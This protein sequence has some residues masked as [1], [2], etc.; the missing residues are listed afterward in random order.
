MKLFSL[1]IIFVLIGFCSDAQSNESQF[2]SIDSFIFKTGPL[3]SYNVA[4]ITDSITHLFPNKSQKARAIYT[5]IANHISLDP[6]MV[7]SADTK[8]TEPEN[9]ILF[10]KSNALGFSLLF[11]EMCSQANIR[12]LSVDGFY[13]WNTAAFDEIPDEVN[14]HWNVVQLG[15]SPSEWFYADAALGSGMLDNKISSFTKYFSNVYFFPNPNVFN[16]AHYPNNKAW[17]LGEGPK[18]I[19]EFYMLPM[20]GNAAYQYNIEK[21]NP[22]TGKLTLPLNKP[23]RFSFQTNRSSLINNITIVKGEG[24]KIQQAER[25]NFSSNTGGVSFD[26]T[27]KKEEST[28]L[29]IRINGEILCMYFLEVSE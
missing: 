24:Q 28:P 4:S 22:A 23:I 13:K 29:S 5:W 15:N 17:M 10:R 7:R 27:F 6:K 9:V 3:L 16:L 18:S 19:K 14:H 1:S 11:Q 25:I 8:N 21:I 2:A 20:I 26:Y 12:C